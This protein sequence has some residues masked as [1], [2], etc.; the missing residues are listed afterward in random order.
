MDGKAAGVADNLWR[1]SRNHWHGPMRVA[2]SPAAVSILRDAGK[3]AIL[4][5]THA[6]IVHA[7]LVVWGGYH[8]QI[9][10]ERIHQQIAAP[11]Q[12]DLL[13]ARCQVLKSRSGF[14]ATLE[15][16]VAICGHETLRSVD[17]VLLPRCRPIF[18]D[19]V[20]NAAHKR[21]HATIDRHGAL[22]RQRFRFPSRCTRRAAS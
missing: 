13:E 10:R 9:V 1:S 16:P 7:N 12:Y 4:F 2:E 8:G 20:S 21:S 3:E 14:C 18:C 19:V 5:N 6:S 11:F 17:E 15:Y 22:R